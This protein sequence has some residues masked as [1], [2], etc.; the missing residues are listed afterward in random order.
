MVSCLQSRCCGPDRRS[1]PGRGSSGRWP[2]GA[3][4]GQ[5]QQHLQS[6]A[7]QM[8]GGRETQLSASGAKVFRR[9]QHQLCCLRVR[10]AAQEPPAAVQRF[11]LMCTNAQ[12]PRD[13]KNATSRPAKRKLLQLIW[14][15]SAA[16]PLPLPGTARQCCPSTKEM[17]VMLTSGKEAKHAAP[18]LC[19]GP[20]DNCAGARWPRDLREIPV[21]SASARCVAPAGEW[22]SSPSAW[23]ESGCRPAFLLLF[24][25]GG[26]SGRW[27]FVWPGQQRGDVEICRAVTAGVCR[28]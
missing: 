12:V 14:V 10:D 6:A 1:S 20:H 23:S 5:Q 27:C 3:L 22:R 18:G 4:P 17:P 8:H 16:S 21:M 24:C 26:R 15:P 9:W 25:R 19:A 13:D 7:A 28:V 2:A 11:M